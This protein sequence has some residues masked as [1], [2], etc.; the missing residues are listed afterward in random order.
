MT[1]I[2]LNCD[3]GEGFGAWRTADD[4]ALLDID[5]VELVDDLLYQL[6]ALAAIAKVLAHARDVG[7]VTV[8][9]AFADRAYSCDGRL[10]PRRLP[11]GVIADPEQ[12]A[13][14]CARLAAAGEIVAVDGTVLR[15]WPRSVCVHSD[16]PDAVA[17]A[18]VARAALQAAGA[19]VRSFA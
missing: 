9:E 2:D 18:A 17:N 7:L 5:P 1:A 15:L 3:V 19:E 6:G 14:R 16:T 11:G 4:E 12:V 8:T 13:R 10:L